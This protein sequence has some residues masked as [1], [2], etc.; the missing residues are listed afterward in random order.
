[1]S[2]VLIVV[3]TVVVIVLLWFLLTYNGLIALRNRCKNAASSI[4]VNLKKRHDLIPS[5][6]SA[7]KGFMTHERDV[8]EQVTRLREQAMHSPGLTPQRM[9]MENRITALLGQIQMR[10]EAY[11]ELKSGEN[12]LHLQRSLTELEE[13][14]SA[15]RRS[16]NAAAESFNNK[17]E[18]I[19]SSIV[20]RMMNFEQQP[21]FEAAAG[22]RANIEVA[23]GGDA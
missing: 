4:D 12:F 6:V 21:F 13:Q 23:L 1:M 7:V 14:I 22:E 16:Y 17:V 5:L 8:L 19:P 3:I 11:P 20:A 10:S 18:M 15:A 2:P 9:V